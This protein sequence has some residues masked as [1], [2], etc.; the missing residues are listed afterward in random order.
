MATS[1]TAS[2]SVKLTVESVIRG[3]HVYKEVWDPRRGDKFCLKIEQFNRHDRYA[4]AI[5]VDENTTVGHVPR[6]ISK[7]F[8]YFL[9]CNGTICG[10]VTGKRQKSTIEGKGLEVPCKYEFTA[11][12]RIVGKLSKLLQEKKGQHE[13]LKLNIIT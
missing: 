1:S 3:H 5:V 12:S 6:E 7:V 2:S 10:E 11:A 8:Y 13:K 9:K 4:V